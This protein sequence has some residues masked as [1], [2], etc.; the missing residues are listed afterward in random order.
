MKCMHRGYTLMELLLVIAVI[1]I[2]AAILLP[3]LARSRE[4]SRRA[5]CLSNL[6]QI[7]M[8]FRMFALENKGGLPWS[9]GKGDATAL[10]QLV[11]EYAPDYRVFI[12]PSDSH[13]EGR[14]ERNAEE[15][16]LNTGLDAPRSLR[17]SYDYLGAYT[18]QPVT[19]PHPSRPIPVLPVMWDMALKSSNR[20]SWNHVPGGSNVLWL[21]GTVRFV[22]I[23]DFA[24]DNLP[25]RVEGY[26]YMPPGQAELVAEEEAVPQLF[27]R[28]DRVSQ[29][30]A[31]QP[32][33]K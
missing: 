24:E 4:A 14:N 11:P 25:A 31:L 7:G 29:P 6:S 33:P 23:E 1:G 13:G 32:L 27:G 9:G 5:S 17:T 19:Y 20:G 2:L 26:E 28:R 10:L 22:R 15:I 30:G 21:D 3:A 12:C 18:A 8:S 16:A